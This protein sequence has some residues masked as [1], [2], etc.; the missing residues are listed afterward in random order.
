MEQPFIR[1]S[2]LLEDAFFT[3]RDTELIAAMRRKEKERDRKSELARI[4]GIADEDVLD[5]LVQHDIRPETLAAFSLVPVIEVAWS[6]GEIQPAE[7]GV[8]MAALAEAGVPKDG[9]GY[10]LVERWLSR[11]PEPKLMRLWESYT[12]AL[13]KHLPADVGRRIQ[14]TVLNHARAVATA[15]GGFL[16]LG[17]ISNK[18]QEMLQSLEAAF[19]VKGE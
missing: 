9:L 2:R 12:K 8:L 17:R 15:A 7:R 6:D 11:R 10:K 13:I 14:E 5:Q 3:K 19:E 1:E 4:C 16:G 18:E